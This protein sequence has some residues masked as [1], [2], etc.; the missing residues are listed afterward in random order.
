MT[1]CSCTH[2]ADFCEGPLFLYF[3][4]GKW[5]RE[6]K[7]W[8]AE[9]EIRNGGSGIFIQ[10]P[11]DTI[12]SLPFATS[13]PFNKLRNSSLSNV[14]LTPHQLSSGCAKTKQKKIPTYA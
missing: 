3:F 2:H 6:Y 14:F 12:E 10:Y 11:D 13:F 1:I 8:S 4:I 7:D 5:I 9:N